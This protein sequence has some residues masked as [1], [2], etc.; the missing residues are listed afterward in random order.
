MRCS[1][2]EESQQDCDSSGRSGE[3]KGE[4][5][6]LLQKTSFNCNRGT[7]VGGSQATGQTG[8]SPVKH[9]MP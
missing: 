1:L 7:P 8:C 2:G 3:N 5:I 6:R 9:S 4:K